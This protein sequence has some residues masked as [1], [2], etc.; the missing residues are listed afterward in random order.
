M[1]TRSGK[2]RHCGRYDS[3][4]SRGP[5]VCSQSV[6]DEYC[7]YDDGRVPIDDVSTMLRLQIGYY[8]D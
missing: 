2:H 4:G 1:R 8:M 5:M 6:V 3:F 7:F